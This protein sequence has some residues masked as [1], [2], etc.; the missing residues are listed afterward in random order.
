MPAAPET[1]LPL[2]ALWQQKRA[3]RTRT[4]PL[5]NR[6]GGFLSNATGPRRA[7]R[8]QVAPLASGCAA[9]GYKPVSGRPLFIIQDPIAEAGG[10][11]LYGFCGN[12]AVNGI[13]VLG[14]D[15]T[16]PH[17]WDGMSEV[18]RAKN[19]WYKSR[20]DNAHD[21]GSF[22]GLNVIDSGMYDSDP[23]ADPYGLTTAFE[24][25]AE[26]QAAAKYF[27][28]T[29]GPGKG[30]HLDAD[31]RAALAGVTETSIGVTN[32]LRNVPAGS[33][34]LG[35][36]TVTQN[37]DGTYTVTPNFDLALYDGQVVGVAREEGNAGLTGPSVAEIVAGWKQKGYNPLNAAVPIS[38]NFFLNILKTDPDAK[39]A[40]D[41]VLEVQRRSNGMDE[42]R[43]ETG[44]IIAWDPANGV[45]HVGNVYPGQEYPTGTSGDN[46][47]AT[48]NFGIGFAWAQSNQYQVLGE[49]HGHPNDRPLNV[50][51]ADRAVSVFNNIWGAVFLQGSYGNR[52][53]IINPT[54]PG[55]GLQNVSGLR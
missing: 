3:P 4:S 43:W 27:Q 53:T 51:N 41:E 14:M 16:I 13:D 2:A 50:S 49:V 31:V 52:A 30:R 55:G 46:P 48:I 44:F 20:Y 10:I 38:Q 9:H 17:W 28:D 54:V 29:G 35:T 26:Q 1:A 34:L 23:T 11:N 25:M 47:T 22:S 39:K 24:R 8:S 6:V 19:G 12:N 45:V 5:K 18:D 36:E 7:R 42:F 33:R 37:E 15:P 40:I 32:D 21:A